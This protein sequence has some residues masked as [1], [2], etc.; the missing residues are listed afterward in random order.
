LVTPLVRAP[1]LKNAEILANISRQRIEVNSASS[2][3]TSDKR[4]E[5]Y[6]KFATNKLDS[7]FKPGLRLDNI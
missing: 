3:R 7:F 4:F 2:E 1:E 6:R 5:I